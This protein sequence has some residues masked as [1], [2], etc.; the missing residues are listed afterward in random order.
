[1]HLSKVSVSMPVFDNTT[2]PPTATV[3]LSMTIENRGNAPMPY[4]AYLVVTEYYNELSYTSNLPKDLS[5]IL[6]GEMSE[7]TAQLVLHGTRDDSPTV[8]IKITSYTYVPIRFAT[9]TNSEDVI[10]GDQTIEFN[11]SFSCAPDGGDGDGAGSRINVP[12]VYLCVF[13]LLCTIIAVLI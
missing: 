10:I 6:P 12:S 1:M 11:W 3:N 13:I 4:P 5:T 7:V 9:G 2:V 8:E